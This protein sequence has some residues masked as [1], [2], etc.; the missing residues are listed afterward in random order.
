M[1]LDSSKACDG[2]F[3]KYNY[4]Y[5]G[6]IACFFSSKSYT[7]EIWNWTKHKDQDFRLQ[8]ATGATKTDSY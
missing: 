6:I 7:M 4:A 3:Y 2:A 5:A 8:I 1:P